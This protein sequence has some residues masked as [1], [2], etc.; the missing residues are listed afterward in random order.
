MM[1]V[2]DFITLWQKSEFLD[3]VAEVYKNKAAA[4]NRARILR[5]KG[6]P[7]KNLR[8]RP[9]ANSGRPPHDYAALAELAK[10]LVKP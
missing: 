6:V 10:S 5:K 2:A 9:S 1:S 7:L 4:V 3:D 8:T